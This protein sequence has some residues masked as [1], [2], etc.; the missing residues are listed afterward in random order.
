MAEFGCDN[1]RIDRLG[2]DPIFKCP[3]LDASPDNVGMCPAG[4]EASFGALE[5][6]KIVAYLDCDHCEFTVG[7]KR[8]LGRTATNS[9]Y[10]PRS[11]SDLK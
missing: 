8:K 11:L 1:W 4:E 5:R 9:P 7:A 3:R 2:T 6:A 10:E